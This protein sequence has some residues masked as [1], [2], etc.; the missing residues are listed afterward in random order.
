MS[1]LGTKRNRFSAPTSLT[2]NISNI[3]DPERE[4]PTGVELIPLSKVIRDPKNP[5]Q[6]PVD[7]DDP[8]KF[9]VDDPIAVEF[10]EGLQGLARAIASNNHTLINPIQVYR[11]GSDY[12]L[13][14]GQRRVLA[15]KLNE[16]SSIL[17]SIHQNP[18]IRLSQ[19]AENMQRADISLSEKL[20][21]LDQMIAEA[22]EL[23]Q[24]HDDRDTVRFLQETAGMVRTQAY[25][26]GAI[27]SGAEEVRAAIHD[28][29]VT[30]IKQAATL[31]GLEGEE[32]AAELYALAHPE[33][34][35]ETPAPAPATM[36]LANR[37]RE[38]GR[39]K[40]AVTIPK[41]TNT[42]VLRHIIQRVMGHE[43]PDID[44]Q[45]L[46]AVTE[47]VKAMLKSVET[48]I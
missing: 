35:Q 46:N 47:A 26:W 24:L 36:P 29:L 5:R 23:G 41:I 7:W 3:V 2:A 38:R 28:G 39:P 32:L 30:S 11:H 4:L 1:A 34:V 14:S 43:A 20:V 15:T 18:R 13:V 6:I 48:K 22:K 33:E 17:A 42:Q 21:S 31:A 10:F 37:P 27:L 9:D 19:Y 16:R 44:W 8:T 12:V 45:D 25:A 40:T